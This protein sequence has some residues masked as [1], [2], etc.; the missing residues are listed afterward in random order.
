MPEIVRDHAGITDRLATLSA[1]AEDGSASRSE[2]VQLALAETENEAFLRMCIGHRP[3]CLMATGLVW[4]DEMRHP[5]APG[6]AAKV[7]LGDQVE[8]L[9]RTM[10]ITEATRHVATQAGRGASI[11]DWEG[12]GVRLGDA[13]RLEHPPRSVP[14]VAEPSSNYQLL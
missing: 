9:G 7:R 11:A 5:A 13:L 3:H 1:K 8:M 6:I 10:G 12:S 4:G 14:V 2:L